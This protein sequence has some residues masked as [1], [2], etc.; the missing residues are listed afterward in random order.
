[1]TN[2]EAST[3]TLGAQKTRARSERL[4]VRLGWF[5]SLWLAGVVALGLV[6]AAIHWALSN[7]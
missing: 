1:L 3:P 6:A 4:I 2:E 5:L 7:Q